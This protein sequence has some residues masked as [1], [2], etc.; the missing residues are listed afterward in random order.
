MEELLMGVEIGWYQLCLEVYQVAERSL[1]F[2][3]F[4]SQGLPGR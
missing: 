3:G 4:E 1:F 2:R